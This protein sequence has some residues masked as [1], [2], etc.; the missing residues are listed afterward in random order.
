[1]D[2]YLSG[3]EDLVRG[4]GDA[5]AVHSVASFFLSR[6]DAE[7]ARR[8]GRAT[9]A[10]G[11]ASVA[12]WQAKAA[13]GLFDETCVSPRWGRLADAGAN[14]QRLLWASTAP[15]DPGLGD[16]LYVDALIGPRTITTLPEPTIA[17][18]V[19]HG[20]LERTLDGETDA[21]RDQLAK[22]A[23]DGVALDDVAATLERAGIASFQKAFDEA[24]SVV[25]RHLDGGG[26][27]RG[28]GA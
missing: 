14:V 7:V 10:D 8:T 5:S 16:T 25:E 11:G 12:V 17:A 22:V 28:D 2:A 13:Y 19:D 26:R 15:K 21:A 18:F 27:H 6:V 1:V 3:L 23:A 24:V 9:S 20:R 4:G